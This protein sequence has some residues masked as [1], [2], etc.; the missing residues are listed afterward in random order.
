L[1]TLTTK[2]G[3][4]AASLSYAATLLVIF[5]SLY[6]IKRYF[7]ANN[8]KFRGGM[9]LLHALIFTANVLFYLWSAV[10]FKDSVLILQ[11]GDIVANEAN[12]FDLQFQV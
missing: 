4:V 7:S 1:L 9:M 2:I 3:T 6:L 5:V 11:D 12:F 10:G 8:L